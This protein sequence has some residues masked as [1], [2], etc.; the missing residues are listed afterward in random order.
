MDNE[1]PIYPKN[2][3]IKKKRKQIYDK[4]LFGP[5]ADV[6]MFNLPNSSRAHLLM[7]SFLQKEKAIERISAAPNSAPQNSTPPN[8]ANKEAS[9]IS[10]NM[11]NLDAS[12]KSQAGVKPLQSKKVD[13]SKYVV[14]STSTYKST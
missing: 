9:Q 11:K 8:I 3:M 7:K 13:F 4:R 14:I 1:K 10:T 6:P 2:Q 12:L 5:G